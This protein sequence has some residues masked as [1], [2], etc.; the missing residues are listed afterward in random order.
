MNARRHQV[1]REDGKRVQE[2]LDERLPT[3][4]L[5]TGRRPLDPMQELGRGDRGDPD[6]LVWMRGQGGIELKISPLGGDEDRRINQRAHG[7]RGRRP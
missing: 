5:G 7:D 2:P 6:G 3:M 1:E 4:P